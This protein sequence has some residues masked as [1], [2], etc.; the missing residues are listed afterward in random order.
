MASALGGRTNTPKITPSIASEPRAPAVNLG[1][2]GAH[3]PGDYVGP[4]VAEYAPHLDGDADPGEIVWM[5]VPF[6][7]DFTQGKDRPVVIVGRDHEWLLGLMLSSKDHSPTREQDTRYGRV[8]M[9]IGTGPWDKQRRES[10]VRLD[11]VIRVDPAHV[12]REGAILPRE[13]FA[14]VAAELRRHQ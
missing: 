8:W 11:R 2:S 4:L 1:Q 12:R 3:Y 7:E 14:R 5:W 13:V 6:E 10:E 9:D